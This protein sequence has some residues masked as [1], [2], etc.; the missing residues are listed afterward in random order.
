MERTECSSEL[1]HP[2]DRMHQVTAHAKG[3]EGW[4]AT[5]QREFPHSAANPGQPSSLGGGGS[6][7]TSVNQFDFSVQ[8]FAI[9]FVLCV[10]LFLTCSMKGD[11][12]LFTQVPLPCEV[13]L[14]WVGL[15]SLF[16]PQFWG[17]SSFQL[18]SAASLI[19]EN[20]IV[21]STVNE[22]ALQG[23]P[24]LCL[25]ALCPV[26]I[27]RKCFLLRDTSRTLFSYPM[28]EGMGSPSL[29]H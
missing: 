3:Q 27:S 17:N 7:F 23:T 4:P 24:P 19:S 28:G 21:S 25:E 2:Q 8:Q 18:A 5:P 15:G 11:P 22:K 14:L 1:Q 6:V 16:P 20:C 29:S 13:G 26:G 10:K 12:F 9:L